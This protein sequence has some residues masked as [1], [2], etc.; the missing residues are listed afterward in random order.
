MAFLLLLA[1]ASAVIAALLLQPAWVARRRER[2]RLQVLTPAQKAIIARNVP[3]VARLPAGLARRL[4]GDIQVFLAE[5]SFSGCAGFEVTDE[6]RLTIAA[7]ACMLA[8]GRGAGF[9]RLVQI[10]VYPGAFVVERLRPEPSGILQEQRQVL[11]GESWV[12]GQVVLSWEDVLAG[13][14]DPDDGRNVVLHEFAHQ[15]DQE[16]GYANGAPWVPG[17]ERRQRW[18]EVFARSYALLQAR[19]A[20]GLPS[21]LSDYGATAPA[22]FFAVACEVFFERPAD[23]ALEDP[24]LYAELRGFLRVDPLSW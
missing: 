1:V 9:P 24:Q 16:K 18:S 23:L 19:A 10:L 22:E 14:R 21:L 11:S 7:Q 3:M 8:L 4:E 15:L 2:L 6:V 20:A 12:Q 5:K 17:R 13:A